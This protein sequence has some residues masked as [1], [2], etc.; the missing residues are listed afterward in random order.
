M[1]RG[2]FGIGD[3]YMFELRLRDRSAGVNPV[4]QRGAADDF[5][6]KERLVALVVQFYLGKNQHTVVTLLRHGSAGGVEAPGYGVLRM[7]P[8][9]NDLA[10]C[11]GR[12]S[13]G[14]HVG[15]DHNGDQHGGGDGGPHHMAGSLGQFL[16]QRGIVDFFRGILME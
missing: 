1:Q 16:A 7:G 14:Y 8:H 10:R 12:L 3:K 13:P 15:G 2:Q 11:H 5:I 6:E 4:F 9:R